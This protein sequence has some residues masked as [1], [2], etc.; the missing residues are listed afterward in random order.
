MRCKPKRSTTP[1]MVAVSM[2]RLL[3]V[4][5]RAFWRATS[6]FEPA[7]ERPV[8]LIGEGG[9]KM[10]DRHRGRGNEDRLG[11]GQRVEAV[12]SVVVPHAGRAGAAERHGLDEQVNVY[13]VDAAA[14]KGQF[15]DEP[16]DG[17]LVAAKDEAGER[18]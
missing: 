16:V 13:Q 7:F 6:I 12:F 18:V 9:V 4:V 8:L 17:F 1:L 3:A 5:Q 11:V 2:W 10:L 14:A 15:G